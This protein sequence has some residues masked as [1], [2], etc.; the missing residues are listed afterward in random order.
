MKLTGVDRLLLQKIEDYLKSNKF[1]MTDEDYMSS[2]SES[3]SSSLNKMPM[4]RVKEEDIC[5]IF[6][7][8]VSLPN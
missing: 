6:K 4:R 1:M 3:C 7:D 5:V 2:D 8:E